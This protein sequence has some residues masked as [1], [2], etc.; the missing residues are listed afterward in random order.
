ME[1]FA[2][3]GKAKSVFRL[4]ELASKAAEADGNTIPIA[5]G[6]A[7]RLPPK[8]KDT[9]DYQVLPHEVLNERHP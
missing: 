9:R 5:A 4:I 1:S 3:A 7:K 6:Q 8:G 2:I